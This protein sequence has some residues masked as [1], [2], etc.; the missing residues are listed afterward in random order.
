MNKGFGFFGVLATTALS[1]V[2]LAMA[3]VIAIKMPWETINLDITETK[4]VV[5]ATEPAKIV[6][7][8]PIELDCR[9]RVH[10]E[11]PI[12]GRKD[13]KAFGQ[14][15]RTDTVS[16]YAIG[17]ID[18]CV[19]ASQVRIVA[20]SDGAHKVFIPAEAIEF[21]R[22]R[23]DAHATRDSVHFSKGWVGGLTDVF[24]WVSDNEGLTPAA[25]AYAQSVI[26]GS[27][28]MSA[29]YEATESDVREA[30]VRQA[31]RQGIAREDVTVEVVGTPDFGMNDT[32][33]TLDQDFDFTVAD[34]GVLC[35]LGDAGVA[36]DGQSDSA[37]G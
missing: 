34:G 6:E 31:V 37:I 1:I 11:V 13:H 29:A 15:Y 27:D 26:G 8:E 4:T 17:D 18:T 32:E 30:Y 5:Q 24:P 23:V 22:P 33:E 36:Q 35:E 19:D 20:P 12:E 10:A 21:V 9:S 2:V 3:G 25:Y 14:T 16:M 28:C 7:I